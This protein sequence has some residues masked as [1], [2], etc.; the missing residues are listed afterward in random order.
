MY[1]HCTD[2]NNSCDTDGGLEELI[3]ELNCGR[4]L[5]A[6]CSILDPNTN[7]YKFVIINWVSCCIRCI[8]SS[9]S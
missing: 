2:R 9:H 4:I 3:D 6:Y 8:D 5:Y 7:L 1:V